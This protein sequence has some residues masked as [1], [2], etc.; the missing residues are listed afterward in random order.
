MRQQ[1]DVIATLRNRMQIEQHLEKLRRHYRD[2]EKESL[3]LATN[4][5]FPVERTILLFVPFLIGGLGILYGFFHVFGWDWFS[6]DPDPTWGM[7]SI[8]VGVLCMFMW[9]IVATAV[10]PV[11]RWT[12]KTVNAKSIRCDVRFAK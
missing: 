10:S 2:L 3:E 5:A 6:N 8:F 11:R 4:E 9:Y 1:A 7:T 12:L